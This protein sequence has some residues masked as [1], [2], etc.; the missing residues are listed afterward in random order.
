M[1]ST[2]RLL[3]NYYYSPVFE[4]WGKGGRHGNVWQL[5]PLG[6]GSKYLSTTPPSYLRLYHFAT[7]QIQIKANACE[8]RCKIASRKMVEVGSSFLY[9]CKTLET[10]KPIITSSECNG[11]HKRP[12]FKGN[13]GCKYC[14]LKE[15]VRVQQSLFSFPRLAWILTSSLWQ[16]IS[17]IMHNLSLTTSVQVHV[18]LWASHL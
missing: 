11:L 15:R 13:A 2:P 5:H 6:K 12:V 17:D 14:H 18:I 1:F 9:N 3:H 10:Q 4:C 8:G 16:D 7:S